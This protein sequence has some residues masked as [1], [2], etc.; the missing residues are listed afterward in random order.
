[1]NWRARANSGFVARDLM[2]AAVL[3]GL[4][5]FS[6]PASAAFPDRPIKIVVSFPPGGV[7]DI[8]AR[9]IGPKLSERIGQPVVIENR[10]GAGGAIGSLAVA[11]SPP[12]GY[13][14]VLGTT[15][16]HATLYAM[17]DNPQYHP[18][19][20]FTPV[21][22][23][24]STPNVLI[25]ASSSPFKSLA[26]V[27]AAAREKPGHV[28][29]GSSG[30]GATPQ[31]SFEMLK[32]MAKVDMTEVMYTGN[33][34]LNDT[35]AGHVNMA[36][37]SVVPSVPHIR[38]GALRALAVT[39]AKRVPELPDVPT[40]AESGYP[41]YDVVAWFAL[42]APA[43]TPLDVRR[44]LNE[45][46]NAIMKLP[47]IAE[48]LSALGADLEGGSVEELEA[49]HKKEFERWTAFMKARNIRTK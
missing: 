28:T 16:S 27:I 25:V 20:D 3:L 47:E 31:L 2:A 22:L 30:I 12:D 26:D 36:F 41:G 24:A 23:L 46:I 13:T 33:Q 19:N 38:E 42:W 11:K 9:T 4:A 48:R 10:G 21:I 18:L 7:L 29:H 6:P 39:S 5:T 34:A 49:F 37:Y 32:V 14:L 17:V 1:M 8:L 15:G 45:E 43:G 44:K 35:L 40:V